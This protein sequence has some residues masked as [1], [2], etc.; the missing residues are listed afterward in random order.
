MG[1]IVVL[2]FVADVLAAMVSGDD[3]EDGIKDYDTLNEY[4]LSHNFLFPDVFGTGEN[5]KYLWVM[6]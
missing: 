3:D 2:G 1:G 5:V 4:T 6:A